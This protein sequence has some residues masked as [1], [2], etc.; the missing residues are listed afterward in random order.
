MISL[1]MCDKQLSVRS[2]FFTSIFN[3]ISSVVHL[4]WGCKCFSS[5]ISEFVFTADV[6]GIALMRKHFSS[7]FQYK[8]I[9]LLVYS[10]TYSDFFL[11]I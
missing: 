3:Y 2:S 9:S 6:A 8:V 5:Y 10:K 1:S 7:D 11:I 4:F